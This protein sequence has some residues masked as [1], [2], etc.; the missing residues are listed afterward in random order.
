[1]KKLIYIITLVFLVFPLITINRISKSEAS[2]SISIDSS[3][4]ILYDN[5]EMKTLAFQLDT[6]VKQ[7]IEKYKIPGIA[8]TMVNNGIT[9]LCKGYGVKKINTQ[10]SIDCHTVFRLGS[11]SKGFASIMAGILVHDSLI[12]WNSTIADY[13]P[14]LT[15]YDSSL[16]SKITIKHILSHTSGYPVH[17]YT[18]RLDDNVSLPLIYNE[19]K[20]VPAITPVG[21]VYSYQNVIYCL[22]GDIIYAS[23]GVSYDTLVCAKIFD[24]LQMNSASFGLNGLKANNNLAYPHLRSKGNYITTMLNSRYYSAAPAAGINA[25]IYDMDIWLKALMGEFPDILPKDMLDEIF[26]PT[27]DSKILRKYRYTWK[28]L[29]KTYYGLG[30]RVFDFGNT[31]VVYH[32]GYV[33]GYRAEIAFIPNEKFGIA[34]LSNS[35][36]SVPGKILGEFFTEYII[37]K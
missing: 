25:S 17:T 31:Q 34:I 30:W 36:S 10:D 27:I 15:L 24:P 14:D 12:K 23:Q 4:F 26:T 37:S 35:S 1:M 7:R 20:N 13:L 3:L 33:Q 32:G 9:Y 21:K 2:I 28:N 5:P 8:V 18:D 22:I 29:K 6:I 16:T 19:L 11:V